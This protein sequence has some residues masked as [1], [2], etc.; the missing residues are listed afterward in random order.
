MKTKF[1][2]EAEGAITNLL[3][4]VE[5]AIKNLLKEHLILNLD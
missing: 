2:V 3:L 4:K 5:G 1:E